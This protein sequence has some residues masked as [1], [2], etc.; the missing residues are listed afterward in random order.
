[1]WVLNILQPYRPPR[2]VTGTPLLY[3]LI[4]FVPHWRHTCETQLPLTGIALLYLASSAW[5]I[6]ILDKY[7]ETGDSEGGWSVDGRHKLRSH[8]M[9]CDVTSISASNS[10]VISGARRLQISSLCPP[11]LMERDFKT[12]ST[13]KRPVYLTWA[14]APDDSN[15]RIRL[16]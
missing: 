5:T 4:M 7:K 15:G 2:P 16:K 14:I 1:M 11:N 6:R 12:A 3:L 13:S 10:V 9:A 8:V